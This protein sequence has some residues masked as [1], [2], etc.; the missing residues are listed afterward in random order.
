MPL[1]RGKN[2][3]PLEVVV[4]NFDEQKKTSLC[5]SYRLKV[6]GAIMKRCSNPNCDSTFLYGNEK[7]I[8]PF[9][10]NTL[11]ENADD[12]NAGAR[13][14]GDIP[15]YQQRITPGDLILAEQ[16]RTEV[17]P[18][19]FISNR[20]GGYKEWHGRITEIDHHEL[21]NDKKHKLFNSFFCGEPYQFAHQT[22]EYTI[23]LEN[24]TDGLPTETTDFCL[25][26][27]YMGRLQIGDEV[28]VSAREKR[29]RRVVRSILNETTGS[30]IRPG[31]QLPAWLV[32]III[33]FP[34]IL[35]VTLICGLVW[36]VESGVAAAFIAVM[37]AAI[38][39]VIIVIIGFWIMIKSVFPGRRR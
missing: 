7:T 9:C 25:F 15:L 37:A 19:E 30:K 6:G 35:L 26:G 36:M 23:R 4:A 27:N 14:E 16:T 20:I 12:N 28:V 10:H 38:M 13:N 11:V 34:A 18:I 22:V 5:T 17:R 39:P 24:I 31:L 8:C 3:P 21:F 33:L 29:G 2:K 32:R 1:R